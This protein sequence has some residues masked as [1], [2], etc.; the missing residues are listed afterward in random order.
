MKRNKMFWKKKYDIWAI[1]NAALQQ[2]LTI[3]NRENE[4]VEAVAA[5]LGRELQNTH[6]MT[7]SDGIAVL[8]IRGP[9]FRYANMFT[10]VSG[11]TS[12]EKILNEFDSC[13]TDSTIDSIILDI[14]SP[15]G[16][17]NGC[18]E[19]SEYIYSRRGIKPITAYASGDVASGAYWI[20]AAADKIV[21]NPTSNIGS[22]GVI[23]IYENKKEEVTEIVS[24]QTPNK[25]LSTDTEEGK[26]K[27]QA[28]IDDIA[29]V[30]LNSIA[31]Y[32]DISLLDIDDRFGAG[33]V[34]IGKEALTRG[35]VDEVSSF[36]QLLTN[37]NG[38]I[39]NENIKENSS[40]DED[41]LLKKGAELE[42]ARIKAILAEG[43]K[44]DKNELAKKLAFDANDSLETVLRFMSY[45]PKEENAK[46]LA[47][48]GELENPEIV[49]TIEEKDMSLEIGKRIAE[50]SNNK[51]KGKK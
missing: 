4:S 16:E 39:M 32:R 2:I 40:L 31:K 44:S 5:K 36:D 48:M 24:S 9:L 11:A 19:V 34:F 18:L 1:T 46:F 41:I 30:F 7:V 42:K 10:T 26:A 14:D 49:P 35:M 6:K 51:I 50:L 28:R 22:I 17:V 43:A 29:S 33:D 25:R 21:V 20:A 8:P 23:G 27:L 12:Y 3:S 47:V 37:I 38:N 45:A 15:G 13:I